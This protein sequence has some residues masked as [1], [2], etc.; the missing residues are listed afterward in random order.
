M[1]QPI[2]VDNFGNLLIFRSADQ[3]E[4]YLE[5]IDV[6]NGEYIAYDSE[7]RLLR[8]VALNDY[9]RITIEQAESTPH[10]GGIL[11]DAL[12]KFLVAVGDMPDDI[13]SMPLP[14]LIEKALQFATE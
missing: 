14:V 7:G 3:A 2:I 11:R 4:R 9:D 1:R 5:P 6:L 10:H 12:V 13:G 8:L